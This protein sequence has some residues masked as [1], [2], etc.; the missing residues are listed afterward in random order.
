MSNCTYTEVSEHSQTANETTGPR[1]FTTVI[2]R[3]DYNE[4]AGI[5]SG[6]SYMV[7]SLYVSNASGHRGQFL[8]SSSEPWSVGP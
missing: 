3:Q 4:H 8:K 1:H 6:R 5:Y 2:S 7:T